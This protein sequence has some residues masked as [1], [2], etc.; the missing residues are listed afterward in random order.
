M[1]ALRTANQGRVTVNSLH[2]P[3]Y[4]QVVLRLL[5]SQYQDVFARTACSVVMTSLEQVVI[6]L[7]QG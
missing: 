4:K 7:L 2:A 3:C 5:S 6:T 1:K